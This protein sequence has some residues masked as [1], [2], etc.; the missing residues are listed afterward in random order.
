M[1]SVRTLST[2]KVVAAATEIAR[3][4]GLQKLTMSTLAK[5]VEHSLAIAVPL[6]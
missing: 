5:E 6:H 1:A 4:N 2:E 3:Q